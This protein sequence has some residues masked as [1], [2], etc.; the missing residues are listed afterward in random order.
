M[1]NVHYRMLVNTIGETYTKDICQYLCK[2]GTDR[3]LIPSRFR[4]NANLA[5][6]L[7]KTIYKQVVNEFGGMRLKPIEITEKD[8]LKV[9]ARA[10][11]ILEKELTDDEIALVLQRSARTIRYSYRYKDEERIESYI[12]NNHSIKQMSLF[13][14]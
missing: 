1:G 11:R 7:P 5:H 9:M 2:K 3:I 14:H 13:D 10:V 6:V 12:A 8:R 4:K